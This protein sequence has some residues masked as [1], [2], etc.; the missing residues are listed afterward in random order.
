MPKFNIW[1]IIARSTLT[2]L[3]YTNYIKLVLTQSE[4]K[5]TKE[6][7][8]RAIGSCISLANAKPIYWKKKMK[9]ENPGHY[10]FFYWL[11]ISGICYDKE[12]SRTKYL[13]WILK[14]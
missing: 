4:R 12:C 9:E 11:N 3:R 14:H 8:M 10:D 13:T 6:K 1:K 2:C 5:T 7:G